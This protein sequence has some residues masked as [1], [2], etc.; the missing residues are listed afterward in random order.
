MKD[1]SGKRRRAPE[2]KNQKT[3]YAEQDFAAIARAIRKDFSIEQVAQHAQLLERTADWYRRARDEPDRPKPSVTRKKMGQIAGAARKL[4][5]HLGIRH[6]ADAPDGP[7]DDAIIDALVDATGGSEDDVLRA[8]GQIGRLVEILEG[9]EGAQEID[10]RA[11]IA[12]EDDDRG[13]IVPPRHHGDIAVRDWTL[14]MMDVYKKITGTR[15]SPGSP[16][17]GK[18][19]GPFIRLLSA[20]GTPLGIE[21]SPEQWRNSVNQLLKEHRQK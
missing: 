14:W 7:T 19:G 13:L 12:A 8:T 3:W 15:P 18:A 1:K 9:A 10:R 21:K 11:S 6:V 16:K 17:S 2:R 20:A 4:L 5:H